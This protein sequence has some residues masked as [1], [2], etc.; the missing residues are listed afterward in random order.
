MCLILH[1]RCWVGHI[2]FFVWSNLNFL[3]NFQWI[4]LPAQSFLVLCSLCANMLRSLIMWLIVSSLSPHHQH[5]LFC[6][7]LS[8]LA[9]IGLLLKILFCVVIRRDSVTL[10]KVLFLS[11]VQVF[12]C[13]ML[14]ISP[15][16]FVPFLFSIYCHSVGLRVVSIFSGG[17]NQFFFQLFYVVL[18]SLYWCIDDVFNV[19][20]SFSSFFF[21]N[22]WYILSRASFFKTINWCLSLGSKWE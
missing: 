8:I 10:L 4:T 12:S 3:H 11:N 16:F 13:G 5:L 19:G 6:C 18:E 21:F 2:Q 17:C 14:L 7:V 15:L 22:F 1:D 20:K 9:L